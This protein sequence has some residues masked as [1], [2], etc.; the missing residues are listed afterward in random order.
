MPKSGFAAVVSHT[1]L[2]SPKIDASGPMKSEPPPMPAPQPDDLFGL[3]FEASPSGML[4]VN[5][6]GSIVLANTQAEH[7]FGYTRQELLGQ[8]IEILIPERYRRHHPDHLRTFFQSP[9]VRAMGQGRDLPGRRRDGTEFPIEIG[10][11]PIALPDGPH[12]LASVIDI[13]ERKKAERT[14]RD[15]LATLDSTA[16]GIFIFDP[17]TLQF[18]YVNEGAAQQTGYRREELLRMTPL[19]LK[20]DFDEPGFRTMMAPLISG[21]LRI[22]TFTTTHRKKTGAVLPVEVNLQYF[23]SGTEQP[24]LIAIVRD[25][26]ERKLAEQALRQSQGLFA[27]AFRSGPHPLII[28]ELETGRCLEVNDDGLR[29]FGFQREEVIGHTALALG[30]WPTPEARAQFFSQLSA[31]GSI[32]NLELQFRG[33]DGAFRHCLIACEQI[34]LNGRRCLLTVGTDMTDRKL[35]EATLKRTEEQLQQMQKLEAVGRLAGGVAHNFNNLLTGINGNVE[36]LLKQVDPW[37]PLHQRLETVRT[38]GQKAAKITKQLLTL[39]RQHV[40]QPERLNINGVIQNLSDL[41]QQILGENIRLTLALAPAVGIIRADPGQLDQILLNLATNARDAMPSGGTLTIETMNIATPSPAV[42]LIVRDT[43]HGMSPDVQAHIFEPFFTTKDVGKGTGLGL[44]T[45]YG[46]MAQSGG[47]IGVRSAP[48]KGTAFTLTFPRIDIEATQTVNQPDRQQVQTQ[49]ILLVDDDIIVREIA[50]EMLTMQ[51]YQVLEAPNGQEALQQMAAT[52]SPIHL[53]VTDIMMPGM[54][55]RELAEQMLAKQPTLR[56]VF[57]SGYNEDEL[58]RKGISSQSV[59]F[60]P[61]PFTIN[62]LS[63]AVKAVLD[64]QHNP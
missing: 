46:I 28:T 18:S 48:G 1:G 16:D 61:K 50:R 25:I 27:K 30:L 21:Q 14:M 57:M 40:A 62:S 33:K 31:Q 20:L 35:A 5:R 4:L 45:V 41:L 36:L 22:Q 64:G 34:D 39:G 52:T 51:G 53:L 59:T 11:N 17:Q 44:A 15:A 10:L 38:A 63:A 19:N 49:T 3:V 12:V 29:L 6:E 37:S 56:V 24:R 23:G 60:V 2:E 7:L 8:P 9:S 54:N 26:T 32:R 55:G 43:G 42:Q 13:T 47:T 58:L